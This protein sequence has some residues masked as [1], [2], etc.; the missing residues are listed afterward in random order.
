MADGIYSNMALIT[1]SDT[2]FVLDFIRVVPGVPSPSVKS[3]IIMTPENAKKLLMALKDNIDKYESKHGGL[4]AN[5]VAYP[6]GLGGKG[7]A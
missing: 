2:E 3:R 5:S 4:G 1:H 7:N 6:F